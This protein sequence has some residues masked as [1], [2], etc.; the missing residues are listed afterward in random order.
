MGMMCQ[1]VKNDEIDKYQKLGNWIGEPK[2][3]GGRVIYRY[4][5][6]FSQ[7]RFSFRD[8]HEVTYK[9]PELKLATPINAVLDCE[10]LS[11]DETFDSTASRLQLKDGTLIRIASKINPVNLWVFDILEVGGKDVTS[12]PLMKRKELLQSIKLEKHCALHNKECQHIRLVPYTDNLQDLWTK[13]VADKKEGIVI[14]SRDAPY[15]TSRRSWY[16]VKIKNWKE[17]VVLVKSYE[18][19]NKGLALLMDNGQHC[20]CAGD[21]SVAVK[22]AIDDKG[23]I[24]VEIQYLTRDKKAGGKEGEYRYRFPSFRHMVV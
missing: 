5:K 22:Q 9:Y 20:Q 23:Q 12:L 15:E 1:S 2:Y 14:K 10:V 13:I 4:G 17:D 6:M 18:E 11:L 7:D 8:A 3:D 16:W 19:N 24:R 21:Q